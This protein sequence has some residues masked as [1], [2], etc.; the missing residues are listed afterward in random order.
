VQAVKMSV[1]V[2]ARKLAIMNEHKARLEAANAI[3]R[4]RR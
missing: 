2:Q 1:N 4:D 3:T